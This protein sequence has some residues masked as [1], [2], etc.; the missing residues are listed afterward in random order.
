MYTAILAN[1]TLDQSNSD[2]FGIALLIAPYVSDSAI[3]YQ[4]KPEESLNESEKWKQIIPLYLFEKTI[5][6]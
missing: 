2:D 3:N 5:P 1:S 6:K 4:H